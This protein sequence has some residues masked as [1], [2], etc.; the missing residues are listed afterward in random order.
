M[1]NSAS[2]HRAIYV[3]LIK[4]LRRHKTLF[5]IAVGFMALL[6]LVQVGLAAILK[7]LVD[8]G[9]VEKTSQAAIWLPVQVFVL[10][11]LRSI[12]GFLSNYS[13]MKVGRSVIRDLRS[14]IFAR[15]IVL[16]TRFY[17]E[18]SSSKL[19]SKL[20]YDV[21]QTAIATTDTLT[22]LFRDS[23]TAIGLI[24]WM[25]YLNWQLTL[26][27]FACVPFVLL[28][29]SYANKRFRKTSREIQDS[30]GDIA[31][32]VKEISIAHKVVKIYG[33]EAYESQRFAN[34]NRDNFRKNLRRGKVS[35]AIVPVTMMCV[36]PVFA[37][38]LYI[39]LNY[40]SLDDGGA[41]EFISFLG[42]FMMLMSPLKQ[43]AKINEKIQI[44][45]TAAASVFRI[46]DTE[47][48]PDAGQTSIEDCRGDIHF[49]DVSFQYLHDGDAVINNV[50]LQI[51]SGQRVALVGASGSGK[52][53]IAA[54]L[55]RFYAPDSGSITLDD[56]DVKQYRLTDYRSMISLVS[57]ETVLFD[58][59]VLNNIVYG[60]EEYDPVR[61]ENA[62]SASHV[63]EFIDKL[64]DGLS[65]IVGEHG[66]RLSGGQRQRIA[67]ARAIYKNAPII[68]M[69]EATSA[70]DT[71]SERFV[72]EAMETLL[73]GRTAIIIA[74]R[75]T[76][77]ESADNIIVL[78]EGQVVEQGSHQQLLAK[79]GS[80][81]ELHRLQLT[82]EPVAQEN[83]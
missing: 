61:L 79:Q 42:A 76:T 2:D 73:A 56:L 6:A 8:Q 60:D 18:N 58:D 68:I 70:L 29:T 27:G 5:F 21:E 53:T 49:N 83:A 25:L 54:L 78:Q 39:Y 65:S 69:D 37:F 52:S 3:R 19:V 33:G 15:L 51:K 81:A 30:M 74:H 9:L 71:K 24:A 43:L 16:P 77:I 17:D 75:L 67:I 63:N 4:Y 20:I 80:Y 66:L 40:L 72:Q 35:A 23:I 1:S 57:Q 36:A 14:D 12:V 22:A 7:P 55:M 31:N 44:G 28:V 11:V 26:I 47:P 62:L 13:M 64:P 45:V 46:V 82:Q 48:E 32:N 41:G 34:I 50:N 10:M 59:T 38:V